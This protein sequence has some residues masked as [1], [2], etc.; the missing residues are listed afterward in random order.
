[1]RL[2][3]FLALLP[4][5][6]LSSGCATVHQH[7]VEKFD[8]SA[9]SA[10]VQF[11]SDEV[12]VGDQIRIFDSA[13]R[14]RLIRGGEPISICRDVE[15]GSATVIENLGPKKARVKLNVPTDITVATRFEKV[16]QN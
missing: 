16:E 5:A 11:K 4:F 6:L 3:I 13:C 9:N 8:S 7:K 1:M 12:T 14:T 10:I 15:L 2:L